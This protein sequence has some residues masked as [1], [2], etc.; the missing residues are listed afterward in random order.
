MESMDAKIDRVIPPME[1]WCTVEK[2]KRMARLVV[3]AKA[4]LCV[5]LGVFGG[6]SMV[7]M[8]FGAEKLDGRC[9]VDGIDP[10]TREACLEGSND[11]KNDEWWGSVDLEDILRKAQAAIGDNKLGAYAYI[12][13]LRSQDAVGLYAD[14]SIDIL[15]QDSNHSHEVSTAEVMAWTPKMSAHSFWIQDDTDWASTKQAQEMVVEKGFVLLEDHTKWRIY[16]R[17][18]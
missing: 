11:R 1:G 15:H 9:R 10:F 17:G 3:E 5:E 14:G 16:R 4:R 7:A 8:A 6:R 2:G 18:T 12:R 13:R